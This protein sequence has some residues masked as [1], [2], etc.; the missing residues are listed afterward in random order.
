MIPWLKSLLY[1]PASFN[2]FVRALLFGLG[3]LPTVVNFGDVGAPAYWVG[4][5]LQ[6]F[7]LMVKAG[8]AN[9]KE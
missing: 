4:K 3:E 6:V 8:D 2:N 7:A 5:L 9:P 1:D